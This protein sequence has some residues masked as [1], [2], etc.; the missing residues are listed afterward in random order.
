MVYE[1][2]NSYSQNNTT[3]H[4]T[5]TDNSF[6]VC[7]ADVSSLYPRRDS[8]AKSGYGVD[9]QSCHDSGYSG[10]CHI[11]AIRGDRVFF[12][13]IAL[14][15]ENKMKIFLVECCGRCPHKSW[16]IQDSEG[17]SFCCFY[18]NE[19]DD[20]SFYYFNENET[21]DDFLEFGQ[22]DWCPLED[23]SRGE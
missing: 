6:A 14:I 11:R 9:F 8:D 21:V 18:D 16:A 2:F 22:P 23:Y 5:H 3:I 12:R 13:A 4:R 7:R 15:K 20:D 10:Y 19:P 17:R 1:T